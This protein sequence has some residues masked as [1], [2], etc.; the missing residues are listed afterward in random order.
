MKNK[1]YAASFALLITAVIWGLSYIGVE[2][3]INNGW[4]AF[5]IL[6]LRSFI[7]GIILVWFTIKKNYKNRGLFINGMLCGLFGFLG[8]AVQTYGQKITTVSS[9]AFITSLYII[10]VPVL[11]RVFFKKRE[12]LIVYISCIISVIGC[13]LLN[14]EWPLSFSEENWLGNVLVLISA[15]F[16]AIQILF[17]SKGTKKYNV[18]QITTIELFTMAFLSLV[19]MSIIGDFSFHTEGLSSVI[20][21]AIFSS[22]V[23]GVLQM[24]GQKYLPESVSGI[25]MGSEAIFATFFAFLIYHETMNWIQIIGCVFI[26]MPLILIQLPYKKKKELSLPIEEELGDET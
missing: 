16:F 20:L 6:F 13:F 24:W 25:I 11:T 7:A 2:D 4:G 19:A 15:V 22:G 23:S 17:I 12:S 26:F 5:P 14:L 1:K 10:F 21:V 18:L 3:A 9:T 8:L